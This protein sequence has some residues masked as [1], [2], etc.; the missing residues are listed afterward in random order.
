MD[1]CRLITGHKVDDVVVFDTETTGISGSDEII[2][3]SIVDARGNDIFSSL[4]KPKRHIS[5]TDAERINHISPSMVQSAPTIDECV[6]QIVMAF[7]GKLIVGYN[8]NFDVRMLCQS[9]RDD[10]GISG[11]ATFDVMKEYARVHGRQKWSGSGAYKYSKLA[12]C[13]KGY[14]YRFH[15]HDAREDAVATAYC[16]MRLITDEAYIRHVLLDK[17]SR[18]ITT[19][20]LKATKENVI[21][22]VGDAGSITLPGTLVVGEYTAGKRAGEKRYECRVANNKVGFIPDRSNE[23]IHRI[24]GEELGVFPEPVDV[25]VTMST[26]GSSPTTRVKLDVDAHMAEV[27]ASASE[28]QPSPADYGSDGVA[29]YPVTD[30]MDEA[31]Q[32]PESFGEDD[33]L[34]NRKV[35]DDI[36]GWPG[37]T[38]TSEIRRGGV[39][40]SASLDEDANSRNV[41]EVAKERQASLEG[42]AATEVKPMVA[43]SATV[44]SSGRKSG[45]GCVTGCIWLFVFF[46]VLFFLASVLR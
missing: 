33:G 24:R 10:I 20:Q 12:E 22:L 6:E 39:S 9:L 15:A 32:Q 1:V 28:L 36:P 5:W 37:V 7:T 31:E 18:V 27:L 41:F 40:Y 34:S 30:L 42:V 29:E 2:S 14:G 23:I 45:N 19:T 25:M 13:A 16:F 3:I 8:V 26:E 17:G 21:S 35:F 11:A 4:I 46:L 43:E 38:I 44:R